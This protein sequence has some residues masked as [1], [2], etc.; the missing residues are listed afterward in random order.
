MER[1][2]VV[3]KELD[4]SILRMFREATAAPGYAQQLREFWALPEDFT[5]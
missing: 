2:K 4:E 5:F 3:N 1:R